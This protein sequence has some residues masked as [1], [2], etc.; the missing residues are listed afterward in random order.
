MVS[1]FCVSPSLRKAVPG[2]LIFIL[3][4]RGKRIWKTEEVKD[5]FSYLRKK[6]EKGEHL[7]VIIGVGVASKGN[8]GR[9]M[10]V[11]KNGKE[12]NMSIPYI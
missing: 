11:N 12:K 6:M 5:C 2:S 9:A 1:L 7:E 4:P 10:Q 3:S 8:K